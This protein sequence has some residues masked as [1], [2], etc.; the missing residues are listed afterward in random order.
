MSLFAKYK[1]KNVPSGFVDPLSFLDKNTR[2]KVRT[3]EGD[4]SLLTDGTF[5]LM[6]GIMGEVYPMDI[7]KFEKSYQRTDTLFT[8]KMEYVPRIYTEPE[9]TVYDLTKRIYSCYPKNTS[10]I[11]AKELESDVKLFT[12][13]Y[14]EKY[15]KGQRGDFLACRPD[16]PSDFYIIRRDIFNMTYSPVS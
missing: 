2:I 3:L 12:R 14:E 11:L 9:N 16:D 6:V 7:G 15:M 4:T 1:K 8:G 13:W 10:H 5:Y